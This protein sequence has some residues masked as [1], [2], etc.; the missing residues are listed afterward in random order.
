[1]IGLQ[2]ARGFVVGLRIKTV[3]TLGLCVAVLIAVLYAFLGARNTAEFA[4]IERREIT[5]HLERIINTIRADLDALET[6]TLDWAVWDEAYEYL[7]R[8]NPQFEQSNLNTKTLGLIRLD[9]IVLQDNFDRLIAGLERTPINSFQRFQSAVAVFADRQRWVWKRNAQF[10]VTGG[11]IEHQGQLFLV[12]SSPVIPGSRVKVP[13]GRVTMMRQLD[14]KA[15]QR[16]SEIVQL[17]FRLIFGRNAGLEPQTLAA[18]DQLDQGRS[19]VIRFES[20]NRAFAYRLLSAQGKE[21]PLYLEATFNRNLYLEGQAANKRLLVSLLVTGAA[22]FLLA[23]TLLELGL[24]NR[25]THLARELAGIARTG[26]VTAR[27]MVRGHDEVARVAQ[28]VNNGLARIE[29]TQLRAF[30]FERELERAK[31]LELEVLLGE[32]A[33][34][35]D[36]F[37]LEVFDRLAM[38]AEFR[39][40]KFGQHT[41]RVGEMA[42][43]I[44]EGLGLPA[45]ELKRLRFAARLHDIGKIAIPDEILFKPGKLTDSEWQLMQT[46]AAV[47]AQV[48]EFSRAPVLKMAGEIALTHHERWDGRGYPCF[49]RGEDIPIVGRIVAVADVWDALLSL[50]PYKPAWTVAE[51]IENIRAGSGTRFDPR[52]V[53]VFLEVVA[54]NAGQLQIMPDQ[55][56][57]PDINP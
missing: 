30:H 35:L 42:A 41:Q 19:E 21:P 14:K 9:K 3:L 2:A 56:F 31:R 33:A 12:A 53:E 50:R 29:D 24:L 54:M 22:F 16:L 15:V 17:D 11:L 6:T 57:T 10:I 27:V 28:H 1:M 43:L 49:L 5:L 37:Q 32:R 55:V 46:H 39:D 40:D 7:K 47:G 34:E 23:L 44:G 4:F 36:A 20:E 18:L 51:A 26:D 52:V 38:I 45:D 25:L 8:P 48:L 13:S